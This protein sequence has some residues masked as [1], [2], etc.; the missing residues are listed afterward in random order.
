MGGRHLFGI[1]FVGRNTLGRTCVMEFI[2][3]FG[4]HGFLDVLIVYLEYL[5]SN[6]SL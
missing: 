5:A 1:Y 6:I 2:G 4:V 3:L